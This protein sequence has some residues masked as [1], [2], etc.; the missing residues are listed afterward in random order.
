MSDDSGPGLRVK[1]S[2]TGAFHVT[3]VVPEHDSATVVPGLRPW[4]D[5]PRFPPRLVVRGRRRELG[6]GAAALIAL[7]ETREHAL[8]NRKLVRSGGDTLA[9]GRRVWSMPTFA[10]ATRRILEQK[11]GAGGARG[12]RRPGCAASNGNAFPC[13]GTRPVSE[14]N[15]ADVLGILT[16]I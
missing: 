2:G 3:A 13:I 4:L 10:D 15:S 14:V 8:A 11:R 1:L 9:E 12:K 6:L 7:A 5:G 16:P